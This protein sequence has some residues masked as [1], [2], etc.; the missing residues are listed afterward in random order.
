VTLY[1]QKGREWP[2]HL[3]LGALKDKYGSRPR[4]ERSAQAQAA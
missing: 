4:D 3:L 1:R 2:I